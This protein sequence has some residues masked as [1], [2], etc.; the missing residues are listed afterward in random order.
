MRRLLGLALSLMLIGAAP[1]VKDWTGRDPA[2]E[3]SLGAQVYRENCAACHDAGVNRAPQRLLL[4]D[5]T[6]EAIHAALVDGAMRPQ[7]AALS[8]EQKTAVAEYLSGRKLGASTAQGTLNMCDAAHARFDLAEPPAFTGWGLDPASTHAV[9]ARVSGLSEAGAGRLTLK[10]AFGFPNSSRARSH[11]IVAGGAILVGNHNGS[12]YAL[13]RETGCL[14]WAFAAQAEVRTGIVV[15]P[16]RAGDAKA[17]PLVY[18]GDVKG[19]VYAVNLL[20]GTLAWKQRA[21][22]HPATIIT[23]TPTLFRG[24]LFVPVSSV[25]EA[26]ATSPGYACCNFRGSVVALDAGSGA[27]KWRTWLVEPATSQG[28]SKEGLDKLG[29]SGVAVWNSPSI[30]AARGQLYVATGDNYSLP[31]TGL[32][33]SV[34]ALDLATGRIKWHYQALAEDTWNVACVTRTSSSCPDENDPDADFGAGT[35]LAKA[36][37]GKQFVLAGQKS[38]WV[39]GLDPATGHLVWKT[40][41]GRGSPGGGVHFGMAADNGLLFVPVTDNYFFGPNDFPASPGLNAL[42]IAT[43]RLVWKVPSPTKCA[44][45]Q[46][47]PG[48]GG[49]ITA[50]AGMVIAGSDDGFLRIFDGPTGKLLWQTDTKPS[51]ATVNGIAA[52]GGAI[53]GG[54][55]PI[56]YKGEVIVPSGYGFASKLPGNVLLV[57]E[58]AK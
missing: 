29:P 45:A 26:Y 49:S 4:Q 13:D 40:R 34:V 54:V 7:G 53:S 55:A 48:Y 21:D 11:P 16:W 28:T 5:L 15:S 56:A 9:P 3:K 36:G 24:V 46:C 47:A 14:R 38:G 17:Q 51:V 50:T 33:D 57:Y 43:G 6:P 18:F 2:A 20:G 39:Y 23:G 41:V 10:W 32:S 52:H 42:D 12:V 35:V 1:E 25:E 22:A 31:A 37:N 27:E 19:N 58:V 8:G 30:D 44:T